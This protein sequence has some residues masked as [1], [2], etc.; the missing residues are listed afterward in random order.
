MESGVGWGNNNFMVA[1]SDRNFSSSRSPPCA[2]GIGTRK[3]HFFI[4]ASLLDSMS[5][6]MQI[7]KPPMIVLV[8][9][10]RLSLLQND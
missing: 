4:P 10:Q 2:P 3:T 9:V 7:W 8:I 6:K 5:K 1:T